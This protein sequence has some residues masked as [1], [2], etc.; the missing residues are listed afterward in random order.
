[1]ESNG[2]HCIQTKALVNNNIKMLYLWKLSHHTKFDKA[3][4]QV[5]LYKQEYCCDIYRSL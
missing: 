5:Y 4:S 2:P 1:L 3:Y